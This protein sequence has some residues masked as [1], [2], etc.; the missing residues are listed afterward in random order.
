MQLAFRIARNLDLFLEAK[1]RLK[2]FRHLLCHSLSLW[3]L[4]KTLTLISRKTWKIQ[5]S[6]EVQNIDMA[7]IICIWRKLHFARFY[8]LWASKKPGNDR[9][10]CKGVFPPKN[11]CLT[12]KK[13]CFLAF[14]HRFLSISR[15]EA[16]KATE[17]YA[18]TFRKSETVI[19]CFRP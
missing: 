7:G 3:N 16:A 11:G 17:N 12:A 15:M 8:G 5:P 6:F 2:S 1:F 13:F 19:N 9:G 14:L 4:S 18:V 10:G